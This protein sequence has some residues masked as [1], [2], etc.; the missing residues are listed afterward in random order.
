[1]TVKNQTAVVTGAGSGIGREA[2][3]LFA[4]RG[5]RVVVAD[6]DGPAAE[7]TV[8]RI[9]EAGG[10]AMVSETDVSDGE[11]VKEMF[12]RTEAA[13][14]GVDTL[15][16]NAGIPQQSTPIEEIS[17]ETWDRNHDVNL[18]SV[19]LTTKHALP[20]LRDGGGAVIN[21]ASVAAL[22]PRDG[23]SAYVAA[24]GGVV[25]LSKQLAYELADDGIRVN[26]ICPGPTDTDMLPQF[27]GDGIS[28]EE[29]R[30]T[31][32][33]GRLLDVN[34]IASAAVFLASDEG[35]ML[36]GIALPVDGGRSI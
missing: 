29:Y 4:E 27:T 23:L 24:K 34:D 12:D 5:A 28:M 33:L 11:S 21:Q 9:R 8:S 30:S 14:G 6:I 20:Y 10:E 15:Y 16:N 36:T 35:S 1:M 22:R 18:K 2:A 3:M 7:E 13:Y 32:P 19:F 17:E 25:A 26:A 31:V